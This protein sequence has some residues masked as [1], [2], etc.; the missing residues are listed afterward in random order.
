MPSDTANPVPQSDT[1]AVFDRFFS[2]VRDLGGSYL[3]QQGQ[4]AIAKANADAQA[5]LNGYALVNPSLGPV[6][7]AAAQAEANKTW[8]QRM[9]PTGSPTV[10]APSAGSAPGSILPYILYGA[11]VLFVVLLLVKLLRK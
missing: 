3:T 1:N 10:G 11:G 6:N 2:T 7:P 8:I 9:L 4:L 5:R